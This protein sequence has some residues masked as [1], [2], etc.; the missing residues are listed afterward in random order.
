MAHDAY[1]LGLKNRRSKQIKLCKKER[2]KLVPVM[3]GWVGRPGAI[4]NFVG[5]LKVVQH[6]CKM[7]VHLIRLL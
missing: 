4:A 2:K 5:K 1:I 7:M 6:L 3:V